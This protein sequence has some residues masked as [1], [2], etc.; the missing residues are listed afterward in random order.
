MNDGPGRPL[1]ADDDRL[2][3]IDETVD[4]ARPEDGSI[5]SD[6]GDVVDAGAANEDGSLEPV[7]EAPTDGDAGEKLPKSGRGIA[8]F[9]L[10]LTLTW[11]ALVGGAVGWLVYR[12]EDPFDYR[13]CRPSS[14]PNSASRRSKPNART[15]SAGACARSTGKPRC[16]PGSSSFRRRCSPSPRTSPPI[17]PS[18]TASGGSPRPPIC[19]RVAKSARR[20]GRMIASAPKRCCE[21]ADELLREIDDF[22]LL[23]V[24][25]RIAEAL[26]D[27]RTAPAVDRTGLYLELEALGDAI[28]EL[29]LDLREYESARGPDV[30]DGAA[31]PVKTGCEVPWTETLRDRFSGLVDFRVHRP[32]PVRTLVAPASRRS[33]VTISR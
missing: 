15:P 13:P 11:L 27:L 28:N 30:R 9:A 29:P 19:L 20:R 3:G 24:R 33:C 16:V 1:D 32:A 10:L 8:I 6:S 4:G 31:E 17:H 18:T 23:P 22:G 12:G 25:E 26:A 5:E 7:L 2:D 14:A 21:A